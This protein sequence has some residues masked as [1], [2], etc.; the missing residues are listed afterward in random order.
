MIKNNKGLNVIKN[1]TTSFNLYFF[2]EF[3]QSKSH[4]FLRIYPVFKMST[5]AHQQQRTSLL[6]IDKKSSPSVA[7][8]SP[9]A[10]SCV[11][12]W[13]LAQLSA[14]PPGS[15]CSLSGLC[16]P[17]PDV[18]GSGLCSLLS[19]SFNCIFLSPLPKLT[20]PDLT[21]L[22]KTSVLPLSPWPRQHQQR[23][24]RTPHC[25]GADLKTG[26]HV[27]WYILPTSAGWMESLWL[28]V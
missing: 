3:T 2:I 25:P 28:Q 9:A 18:R 14:H 17:H 19:R 21:R 6:M 26:I 23:N 10:A 12:Q 22:T 27:F 1:I 20:A 15:R 16:A 8:V 11:F 5:I 4:Y 7:E 13:W 24:E